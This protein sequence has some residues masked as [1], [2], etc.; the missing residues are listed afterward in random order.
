MTYHHN[1][2]LLSADGKALQDRLPCDK[3][4]LT[5]L[6]LILKT[7]IYSRELDKKCIALQRTG[8]LGTFAASTGQEAIFSTAGHL[9]ESDDVYIPY[10]RDQAALLARGAAPDNILAYWGGDERGNIFNHKKQDMPY[11]VPIASQ[12]SHAAGIAFAL[13]YQ[14][15]PQVALVTL[16]DGATSK[17]D[18]YESINFSQIHK[19]PIVYLINNNQ[20]SISV[21]LRQQSGCI[22]LSKK[23][24]SAGVNGYSVDGNDT[25][26]LYHCLQHA[27]DQ[28]RDSQQPQLIEAITYRIC[29]HT[30]ADDAKRYTCADEHHKALNLDPI[31]RLKHFLEQQEA[32]SNNDEKQHLQEITDQITQAVERYLNQSPQSIKTIYQHHYAPQQELNI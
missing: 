30:T 18:F 11:C 4:C 27:I 22:D 6:Q 24:I 8:R 13:K 9:L 20:W 23:G 10:Y 17:G 12:C 2:Q 21:P 3:N 7:M 31:K 16:G 14:R 19:L 26:A 1:Y 29:D 28:A 32:W 25:L 5:K 15:Q